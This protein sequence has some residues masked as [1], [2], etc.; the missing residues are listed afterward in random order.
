MLWVYSAGLWIRTITQMWWHNCA[1]HH[2]SGRPSLHPSV[3]HFHVMCCFQVTSEQQKQ[4][5]IFSSMCVWAS[6]HQC[7]MGS[8]LTRSIWP[9]V[10]CL[11]C[12][13]VMF[14]FCLCSV[15]VLFVIRVNP[16]GSSLSD[17]MYWREHI[18]IFMM[19]RHTDVSTLNIMY[20]LCLNMCAL[21]IIP[22]WFY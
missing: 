15:S 2:I 19:Y 3:P 18:V 5:I 13:C 9:F 7:S 12:V 16:S 1:A 14:V 10:F 21:W 22:L 6:D 11:C 17:V 20:Y 4:N 8:I